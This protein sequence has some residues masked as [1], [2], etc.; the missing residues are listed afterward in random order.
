MRRS[1]RRAPP[2]YSPSP[3][4][5][6]ARKEKDEYFEGRGRD[7]YEDRGRFP[8]PPY[9]ARDFEGKYDGQP[10]KFDASMSQKSD[11][12][13]I[14]KSDSQRQPIRSYHSNMPHGHEHDQPRDSQ[15]YRDKLTASDIKKPGQDFDTNLL[16]PGTDANSCMPSLLDINLSRPNSNIYPIST[17]G[18]GVTQEHR[19]LASDYEKSRRDKDSH[20]DSKSALANER[21]KSSL[22][23]EN[24]SD[25]RHKKSPTGKKHK[26]DKRKHK[27]KS[28]DEKKTKKR[29][30]SKDERPTDGDKS[31]E[32]EMDTETAQDSTKLVPAAVHVKGA[33]IEQ[34]LGEGIVPDNAFAARQTAPC[35]STVKSPERAHDT[36]APAVKVEP[37]TSHAEREKSGSIETRRRDSQTSNRSHG[38]ETNDMKMPSLVPATEEL[39]LPTSKW[40]E[41]EDFLPAGDAAKN[42]STER[43]IPLA[44]TDS[45]MSIG[46][47]IVTP[48]VIKR[49]E[50]LIFDKP[51]KALSD[52]PKLIPD[53]NEHFLTDSTRDAKTTS[54]I[55]L[56]SLIQPTKDMKH[57]LVASTV[58]RKSAKDRLGS[59]VSEDE[60]VLNVNRTAESAASVKSKISSVV[61]S[62]DSTRRRRSRSRSPYASTRYRNRSRSKSLERLINKSRQSSERQINRPSDRDPKSPRRRERRRS[63]SR[64]KRR[65]ISRERRKPESRE[66]RSPRPKDKKASPPRDIM[67]R[68]LSKSRRTPTR[69]HKRSLSRDRN[70]RAASRDR[71]RPGS[72]DRER[73]RR[74]SNSR[75]RRRSR[76]RS[77]DRRRSTSRR[78]GRSRS[79]RE[80]RHT[81][82]RERDPKYQRSNDP[83]LKDAIDA[84]GKKNVMTYLYILLHDIQYCIFFS[85]V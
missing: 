70:K 15:F 61:D 62:S 41:Y 54:D 46:E 21:K 27:K 26:K 64:E 85:V 16:P 83:M 74:R 36:E 58:Y 11:I 22:D 56:P 76:S 38:K 84:A 67:Q 9:G 31:S 28:K 25:H 19:P 24:D 73:E 69:D 60:V 2:Q 42:I 33:V 59:K 50:S 49:A 63:N 13:S 77:R 66:Q 17:I 45:K 23:D 43:D 18:T 57:S 3:P 75:S 1:P 82:S 47:R 71:R 78:R 68:S 48:D 14:H 79:P 5:R 37:P 29:K 32:E 7:R 53:V 34:P 8:K 4:S 39:R 72:R 40:D 80:R 30:S 51:V 65:S 52:I 12:Q 10:T 81:P 44:T 35:D 55:V 20:A 6:F